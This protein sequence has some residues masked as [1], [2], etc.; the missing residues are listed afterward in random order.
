MNVSSMEH[1]HPITNTHLGTFENPLGFSVEVEV[2][3]HGFPQYLR[4]DP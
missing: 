3:P 2:T 4:L 1:I